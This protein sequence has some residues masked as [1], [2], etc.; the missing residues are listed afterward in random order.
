MSGQN[1][2]WLLS[3]SYLPARGGIENYLREVSRFLLA[4]GYRPAVICRG[5]AGL[6]AEE[7]I[8]GVRVIRHPDFP[9][10]R[11]KLFSKH[12]YL[13][14][15]IAGW[16]RE[17]PYCRTGWA[18][19][20]YPHY[21]FALSALDGRCPGI[22]L[23]AAIWPALAPLSAAAGGG[24]ERFFELFW[25]RQVTFLERESLRRADRVMVF[26]G[27]LRSQ[28][29]RYHAIEPK[30]IVINPPGVDTVRFQP[31][32]PDSDRL[33]SLNIDPEKPRVLF[34]GRFSPEKNLL[35][36]LRGLQPLLRG[37]RCCL[38][39]A[40]DGPLRR[41]LEKEIRRRRLEASVRLVPPPGRPE[42]I[43]SL[44]DI[45][46]SPSRY[47]SFGQTILEA[48]ASGL[49]VVALKSSPPKVLTAAAEIIEEGASGYTVF[50]D[51]EDLRAKIEELLPSPALRED[52]GR[53]GREIC[54][55]RFRW[56]K[57]VNNLL[58]PFNQRDRDNA[59]GL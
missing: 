1:I 45:F 51:P 31:R 23:P 34:L 52:L 22:Y 38:L 27:N 46:V 39:L 7:V 6:A 53:R 24:K 56:E 59:R 47:E 14:G 15:K 20:R 10:P 3:H 58:E 26:S 33:L 32:P 18:L 37:S 2:V 49:P 29:E 25:R 5:G 12:L 50:E 41:P 57:H 16:M 9:V 42:D 40:G 11:S 43:Y 21:Q 17:S 36:L 30:N 35:F 8:E 19:C 28:I 55:E 54:R 13:A 48:M 44:G 4:L